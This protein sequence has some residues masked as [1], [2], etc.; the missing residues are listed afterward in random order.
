M[1]TV[2]RLLQQWRIRRALPYIR[3]GDRLLDVGCFDR[4]LF[5]RA[6]GRI[7]AAVGIDPLVA[8]VSEPGLRLIQDHFPPR[9]DLPAGGF[10]CITMLAVFEH[11]ENRDEACQACHDLLSP[12]GRVILTV[13]RPEVDYILAVL[14][15][16]RIIDGMSLEEHDHFDVTRTP[17]FF[18]GAGFRLVAQRRFQ[19]GLNT[20]FVFEKPPVP[21]TRPQPPQHELAPALTQAAAP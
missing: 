3:A 21:A 14:K 11:L 16:L 1:R 8:P 7:S 19:L 5:E 10:D 13:P 17:D 15:A 9:E 12:G 18:A 2:D 4:S 20:L 6:A